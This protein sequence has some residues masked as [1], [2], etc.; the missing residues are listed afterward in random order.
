MT[1]DHG[2]RDSSQMRRGRPRVGAPRGESPVVKGRVTPAEFEEL[3]QIMAEGS[4]SQ[5]E[6]VRRG[7]QLVIQ[8]H[9]MTSDRTSLPD[10][11]RTNLE[12]NLSP[13]QP[14]GLGQWR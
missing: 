9:R 10:E 3:K 11:V 2:E 12:V 5:S 6:V 7:V 14:S 13:G 4:R 1:N 8:E